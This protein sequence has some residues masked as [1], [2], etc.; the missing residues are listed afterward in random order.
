MG[1]VPTPDEIAQLF[2]A[3]DAALSSGDP[4]AVVALYALDAVLL[5]TFSNRV[6]TTEEGRRDYFVHFLQR[7]PRASVVEGHARTYG[8]VAVHSGIYAFTFGAGPV[9]EARARFTFVYRRVDGRWRIVEHH[10]SCMPE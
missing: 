5:P 1:A 10:S 9:R 4:D 6:R 8:D 2:D 7:R 3:W